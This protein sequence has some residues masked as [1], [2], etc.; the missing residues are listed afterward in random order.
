MIERV[1]IAV[2]ESAAARKAVEY[3]GRT[4]GHAARPGVAG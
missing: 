2:A 4:F 1:L 3:V